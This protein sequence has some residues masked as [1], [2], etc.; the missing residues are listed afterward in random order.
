MYSVCLSG[1]LSICHT[2]S[3]CFFFV[4][5]WKR[6]IFWPSFLHVP[7][8]KTLFFNFW[9][10]PPNVQNLL[11][12][13]CT[14]SPISRLVWQIDQRCLNLPGGFWGW[15]IQWNHAKFCGADPCCHGNEIWVRRRDPDA[16]QLVLLIT[17]PPSPSRLET[18]SWPFLQ[19]MAW[20][21]WP[22][23]WNSLPS[24]ILEC[25]TLTSFRHHLRP[26]TFSQLTLTPAPIRM[27]PDSIL[28]H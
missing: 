7:L 27:S 18:Q 13:I 8:Y 3:N 28:R 24:H 20:E 19:Q 23:I 11:P 4:S 16:Y 10:K 2:P 15:P 9:F 21:A 5:R 25:Q 26:T 17:W 14:K 1:C 22:K 12:K 6:A